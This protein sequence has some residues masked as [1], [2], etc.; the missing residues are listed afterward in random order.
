MN[1]QLPEKP[2]KQGKWKRRL[3][4]CV[5]ALLVCAIVALILTWN[6]VR[7][8]S[9]LERVP[10]TNAYVM[11][12]YVDYSLDEIETHGMDVRNIED[13]CIETFFPDFVLPVAQNVKRWFIPQKIEA[14]ADQ[15]HHCSS[16]Y[17]RS[18]NGTCYFARNHDWKH[19]AFLILR[20][21][22]ERGLASIAT[23]DLAYLNLDRPD[24]DE[25]NLIQRIPLLFAPY[26]AMDGINRNGVAVGIMSVDDLPV[27]PSRESSNP[28]VINTT[29]MRII[30]DNAKSTEDAAR[31]ARNYNVHFVDAPQHVLIGDAS[32]KSGIL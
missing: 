22:D 16:L 9:S 30:L 25:T 12:Y 2:K 32:G 29:L 13:S 20:I 4:R 6:H 18:E 7:T 14:T 31:I 3:K 5:I 11:N 28:N 19:D 1:S 21:Y 17:L 23:I 26:Y 10:G 24:L 27:T 15:G 8:L